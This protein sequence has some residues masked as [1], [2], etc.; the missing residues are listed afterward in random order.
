[1]TILVYLNSNYDEGRTIFYNNEETISVPF[2]PRPG[3][4]T[5]MMQNV[6]HEGGTLASGEKHVIRLDIIYER[7]TPYDKEKFEKNELAMQYLKI[8]QDLERG[9]KAM[10][11]IEYY[12]KAFKLNPNLELML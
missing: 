4:A 1:M 9:H 5:V 6:I 2:E 12:K 7:C 11:S 3:H 8:A 10:E